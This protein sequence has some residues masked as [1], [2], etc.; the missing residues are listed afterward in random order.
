MRN[1]A[2]AVSSVRRGHRF[3]P[4]E[5]TTVLLALQR[6]YHLI[7]QV[8]YIQQLHLYTAVIHLNR[9][10]V[11]NIMA[12]RGNG[13]VVVRATPFSKQVR[14][15][16]YQHL[17]TGLLGIREHQ[18]LAGFLAPAVL[19]VAKTTCQRGLHRGGNHHRA[20]VMVFEECIQ[21]QRSKTKIAL[22]KL[23]LRLRTVDTRQIEH[24]I[25]ISAIRIQRCRRGIDIILIYR[26]NDHIAV[27]LRLALLDITEL[28]TQI[29]AHKTLRTGY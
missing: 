2:I 7:H 12:E 13:R 9:Q 23:L 8:V 18:L 10:V 1:R 17:G 22:H 11:R 14:E 29:P 24:K 6:T 3:Y 5:L 26:I 15:T 21:Q 28:R 16:I 27:A 4:I 19:A 25:A 20:S